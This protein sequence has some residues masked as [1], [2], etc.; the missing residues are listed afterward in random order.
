MRLSDIK[1]G[2]EYAVGSE[3]YNQRRKVLE[4]G[5]HGR[6]FS[7]FSHHKSEHANYVRVVQQDYQA[8]TIVTSRSIL[9]LWSEQVPITAA[10]DKKAKKRAVANKRRGDLADA[11]PAMLEAL[12]GMLSTHSSDEH[13]QNTKGSW[14]KARKNAVDA[15]APFEP[16][17]QGATP[18]AE[19][20]ETPQEGNAP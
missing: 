13:A 7:G 17:P 20:L 8:E 4:V 18:R 9:R 19:G 15:I 12:R 1:V 14:L 6:V 2:E 16:D 10:N 5:V 3:G 11:A